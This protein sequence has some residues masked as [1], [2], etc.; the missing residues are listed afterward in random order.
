MKA[1]RMQ[2][3]DGVVLPPLAHVRRPKVSLGGG[4]VDVGVVIL[5]TSAQ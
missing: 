2:G 1:P 3:L 4:V 5:I